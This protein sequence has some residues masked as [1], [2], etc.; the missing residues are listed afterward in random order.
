M[1]HRENVCHYADMPFIKG[2][3]SQT[4]GINIQFFLSKSHLLLRIYFVE[5]K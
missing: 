5:L 4:V 3:L 2:A 1:A